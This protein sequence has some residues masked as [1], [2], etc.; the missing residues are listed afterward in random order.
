MTLPRR[1]R[2]WEGLLLALL[3]VIVAL[4]RRQLALLSSASSNIVNL[5]QLSIEKIIVALMMTLDHH[6]RRDRPVGRLGHGLA[7]CV[8]A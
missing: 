5:F 1:L 6:Q 7:A 3:V 2:G 8:M 4:Q